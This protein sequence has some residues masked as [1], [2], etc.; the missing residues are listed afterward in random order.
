M[1]YGLIVLLY[2][3]PTFGFSQNFNDQHSINDLYSILDRSPT[4]TINYVT[5]KVNWMDSIIYF[6]KRISLKYDLEYM[7]KFR[8]DSTYVPSPEDTLRM[9]KLVET[10]SQNCHSYA[11]EK[12]FIDKEFNDNELFTNTT[13]LLENRYMESILKTAFSCEKVY[14]IKRKKCKDCVFNKGSLIV[15]RNKWNTPIHT[16]YYDGLFQSKYGGW[17]A[18]AEEKIEYVIKRYWDTTAVEEYQLDVNK[19]SSYLNNSSQ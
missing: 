8:S 6:N 5:W 12:Y 3:T 18:K 17:P 11:L 1:K 15:F 19:V 2:F 16:V 14:S 13:S 4:K 10:A 9:G 7:Q